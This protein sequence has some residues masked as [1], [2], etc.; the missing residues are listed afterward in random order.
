[1]APAIVAHFMTFALGE[2]SPVRAYTIESAFG[3]PCHEQIIVDTFIVLFDEVSAPE[4]P[5][6]PNR[7]ARVLARHFEERFGLS[8]PEGALGPG[9]V[10]P[11][12]LPERPDSPEGPRPGGPAEP[13]GDRP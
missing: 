10:P 6:L 13:G 12:G 2:P 4:A 9:Q 5:V 1:M 7:A 11:N 3:D 8:L